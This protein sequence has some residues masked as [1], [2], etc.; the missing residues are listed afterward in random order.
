MKGF[1]PPVQEFRKS[2]DLFNRAK[3][4][5]G[6][7]KNAGSPT[8]ADNLNPKTVKAASKVYHSG[9]VMYTD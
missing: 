1:H 9:F 7:V 5:T 4:D 2:S 6:I 3:W 8:G